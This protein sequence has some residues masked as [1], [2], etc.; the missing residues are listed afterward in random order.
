MFV[1]LAFVCN[2]CDTTD[3]FCRM[4]HDVSEYYK[5]IME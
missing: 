3:F 1:V 5:D 2:L 4:A